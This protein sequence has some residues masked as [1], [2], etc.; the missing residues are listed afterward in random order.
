MGSIRLFAAITP[1]VSAR[2]HLDSALEDIRARAG[3]SLRWT[4]RANWHITLSFYGAQPAGSIDEIRDFLSSVAAAHSP[5]P[6]RLAGAGSFQSNRL[7]IGV[8]G[9]TDGLRGVMSATMLDDNL[10][11]RHRAHLSVA[12]MSGAAG[13]R[14]NKRA[15]KDP[16]AWAAGVPRIEHF[17]RALSVYSGPDFTVD[18]FALFESRLGEGPG[19]AP[20][21]DVLA[22][23]PLGTKS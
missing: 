5:L 1:P 21:Y 7:W 17:V 16:H 12:T 20:A 14:G 15:R 10:R 2:D 23:F 4:P 3:Q 19:G 11:E 8:G 6:I 13:H 18:E 22:R 9:A